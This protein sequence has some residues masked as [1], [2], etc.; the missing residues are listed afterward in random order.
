MPTAHRGHFR[1][2]S[3][4]LALPGRVPRRGPAFAPL[5]AVETDGM[6]VAKRASMQTNER[7]D[8]GGDI[9]SPRSLDDFVLECRGAEGVAVERLESGA[10]LLVETRNS[11]YQF[12]VVDGPKRRVIVKGGT[13]FL[14][15]TP[16]RLDGATAGGS[17]LKL[18]WILVGLQFQVSQGRRRI[19]SSS[20][21]SVTVESDSPLRQSRSRLSLQERDVASV[22]ECAPKVAAHVRM[23]DT[24]QRLGTLTQAEAKEVDGAVFG[25]HPVNV[26]ARRHDSR[27]RLE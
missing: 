16:V 27:A 18:G 21:R 7:E 14:N 10:R 15:A 13:R 6:A 2:A 1:R 3:K 12:I 5:D 17:A 9:P 23:R 20:V 19:R 4:H 11:R 26:P 8:R 24:D 22:G 25:H